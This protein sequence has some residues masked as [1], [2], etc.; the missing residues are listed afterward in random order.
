M[1]FKSSLKRAHIRNA[2]PPPHDCMR[3][4]IT[5]LPY[6]LYKNILQLLC[7]CVCGF[8]GLPAK[9]IGMHECIARPPS[10]GQFF[11]CYC[12]IKT[13]F[14]DRQMPF[15]NHINRILGRVIEAYSDLFNLTLIL[16][17]GL[18]FFFFFK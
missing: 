1:F 5:F 12:C 7:L 18:S 4:K 17:K 11:Y 16:I 8:I 9:S 2:P 15:S 10:P 14:E 13:Y 3:K 6:F